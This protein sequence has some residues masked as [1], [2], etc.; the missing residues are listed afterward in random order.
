MGWGKLVDDLLSKAVEPKLI[1]PTFITDYPVEMSPFAKAHRTDEGLVERW[2]AYVGGFEIANAFTE[3]N[4]PDEQR[5]RFEAQAEELAARRRRGAADGRE[6][7]RG[8]RVGHAADRRSRP[9]H[10]PPGDAPHGSEEPAR[11]RAL[12]RDARLALAAA[13]LLLLLA[14]CGRESEPSPAESGSPRTTETSTPEKPARAKPAAVEDA[15]CPPELAGCVS[16]TGVIAAVERVDP[17]GDGDAHFVLA[18]PESITLPGITVIDVAA[19]LRP[20]PLPRVGET[21]SGAGL[22]QRGS[23]GQRQIEAVAI[24]TQPQP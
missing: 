20:H 15:P 18:D 12:P 11:G 1:Q 5:R 2:E 8:A 19:H 23:Y 9:G 7:H 10:R 13:S 14:G 22:V 21:I 16:A 3:L 6:L 17:D 4:D 24:R